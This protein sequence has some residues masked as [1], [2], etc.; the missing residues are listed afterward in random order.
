PWHRTPGD[1]GEAE[2]ASRTLPAMKDSMGLR[3]R[4]AGAQQTI[5]A[6][7]LL[8][9]IAVFAFLGKN[10]STK[11]NAFEVTRLSV[12]IGL[13]A[14]ALT[15][16][17][18]TGGID[19]SVGSM[20]GLAAVVLGSLWRD[21]G[22]PLPLAAAA[23]LLCGLT[24]GGLNALVIARLN[25]PP[26]IVTLGTFSLFRGIAEGLTRGIENYFGFPPEFL[27]WGQGHVGGVVA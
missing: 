21:A 17:I 25:F 20:V 6:G 23:A 27:F 5:L 9:E 8:L 10:F 26:L 22:L 15:P 7:V 12:E 14:L 24:G 1:R 3:P 2:M 11:T 16:V 19:L 4:R 13:L 18:I